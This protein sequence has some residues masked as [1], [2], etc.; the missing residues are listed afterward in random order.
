[1]N[2]RARSAFTLVELIAVIVVLAILA[3]VAV[4]KFFDYSTRAR[5][6]TICGTLKVMQRAVLT[7]YQDNGRWP[8]DVN[9]RQPPDGL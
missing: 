6:A 1:M 5:A 8:A 3:A 2:P 7:Y 4:P 9:P